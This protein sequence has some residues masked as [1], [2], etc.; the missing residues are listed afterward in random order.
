VATKRRCDALRLQSSQRV[1]IGDPASASE[2]VAGQSLDLLDE[3]GTAMEPWS[4]VGVACALV[5]PA[6]DSPLHW[7]QP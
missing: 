6:E 3:L 5:T 1:A 7:A 2:L 4:D